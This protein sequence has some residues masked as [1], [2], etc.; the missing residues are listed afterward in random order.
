MPADDQ[1]P[2]DRSVLLGSPISD[3]EAAR[4]IAQLLFLEKQS[5][6]KPITLY[7]NSPGGSVT[8]GIAILRTMESLQTKV[9]T[10]CIGQAHSMAAIILAAGSRGCRIAATNSAITFSRIRVGT[11][12]PPEQRVQLDKMQRDLI[13]TTSRLTGMTKEQTTELFDSEKTLSAQEAR[14]LGIID[15]IH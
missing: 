8:A 10:H 13:A 15:E 7:I 9:Y 1:F 3:Q 2:K 5:K 12:T 14:A 11:S 6:D 4:V